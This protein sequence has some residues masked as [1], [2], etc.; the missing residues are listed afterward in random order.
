MLPKYPVSVFY[1]SPWSIDDNLAKTTVLPHVNLL[2]QTG[3]VESVVL[4]AKDTC[5][6]KSFDLSGTLSD[7]RVR[8]ESLPSIPFLPRYFTYI[9]DHIFS[10]LRLIYCFLCYRPGLIFCRGTA[11]IYG[12][13]LSTLFRVPYIVESFEPHAQYMLQTKTWGRTS[14][15]YVVQRSWERAI[16]STAA[17][18]LTVSDLY[19][20]HLINCEK[21][22]SERVLCVPCCVDAE[23]FYYDEHLRYSTRNALGISNHLCFVYVGKF[24]GIY[25]D[26]E[27]LKV[28]ALLK[29]VMR[30]PVYLVILTSHPVYLVGD[31]LDSHG[32]YSD[33]RYI[34]SVDH[35]QV[36]AFLNAADLAMSFI[37]AGD[38]SFACSPV[39]HGEYLAAGLPIVIPPGV[40]DESLWIESE[41]AGAILDYKQF[42][43]IE[44]VA[45]S[46]LSII[47]EPDHR[48]RIRRVA[49]SRRS[50]RLVG[51]GYR[52]VFS[53]VLPR[54]YS[55]FG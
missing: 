37:N 31:I 10:A 52:R 39:K 11:G 20:D 44:Y 15:K 30:R 48:Q 1:I 23:K 43:N 35:D 8:Y 24:G 46:A 5:P 53:D 26:L 45:S 3:N 38:W 29:R 6:I 12:Y 54:L 13:Y 21:I 25:C 32:I 27:A 55:D 51:D 33:A 9:L 42:S 34:G 7:S 19:S 41:K 40:G 2:F 36:N 49:L 22:S 4:F 16:K 17:C 28:F 47:S 50:Y 18:L 14:L